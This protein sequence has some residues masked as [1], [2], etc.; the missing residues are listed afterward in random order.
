VPSDGVLA[1]NS[2]YLD[3]SYPITTGLAEIFAAHRGETLPPDFLSALR[4]SNKPAVSAKPQAEVK[5]Q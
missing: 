1:K 3:K 2:V 5:A 4:G